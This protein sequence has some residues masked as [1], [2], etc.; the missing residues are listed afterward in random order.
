VSADPLITFE[1][2]AVGYGRLAVLKELSFAIA[3]GGFV[4]L[5]GANGSGKSTIL[6]TILG[7][8]PPL[9]GR[10]RI[11][12]INDRPPVVGYVPQRESLD[13]IF[14]MSGFEVALMGVYGRV[15]PGRAV[16]AAEKQWVRQC[17]EETG[18]GGLAHQLFSRLSGG[19][20]QRVL[21]ARALATR[22]DVL[23]LDEPTAGIDAAAT[24]GVL[25]V[26][27]RLHARDGITVLLVSHDL[28]V[29]RRRAREVIWLHQGRAL[30]GPVA[31]LLTREKIEEVLEL[32]FE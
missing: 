18:A 31:T 22:P 7:I 30:Q 21:V 26:L 23:V 2:V 1:N 24:Q 8:L 32:Q 15:G 10:V 3:R 20:K 27:E 12:S 16:R 4:G 11:H 19:Q 28:E 5:L 6:R 25:E 13:S 14:L 17:L 29:V 9:A